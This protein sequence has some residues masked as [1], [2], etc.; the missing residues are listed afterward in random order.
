MACRTR[1][2]SRRPTAM[3]D[4]RLLPDTRAVP[5]IPV[6][7]TPQGRNSAGHCLPSLSTLYNETVTSK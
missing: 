2:G 4:L 7:S 3:P 6:R 1:V 5:L